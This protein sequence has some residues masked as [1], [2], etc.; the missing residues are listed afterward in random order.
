MRWL[1]IPPALVPSGT[2]DGF[3]RFGALGGRLTQRALCGG[4]EW[5]KLTGA[6]RQNV[7]FRSA[8]V[9]NPD[10]YLSCEWLL[11]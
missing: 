2:H 6:G 4:G 1:I 8:V 7:E 10:I 3:L 11:L 9:G 5:G